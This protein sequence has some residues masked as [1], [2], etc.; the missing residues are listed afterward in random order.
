MKTSCSSVLTF[1]QVYRSRTTQSTEPTP[2]PGYAPPEPMTFI[3]SAVS[4]PSFFAPPFSVI[5]LAG[6]LPTARK[7]SSRDRWYFTGRPVF[8][9]SSAA[10]TVCL[11]RLSFAPN[12]PPM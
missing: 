9:A 10:R 4:V 8:R 6:R 3:C 12:P 7:A 2:P 11:L 1:G 5:R